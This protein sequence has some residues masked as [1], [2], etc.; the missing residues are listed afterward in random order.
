MMGDGAAGFS[1]MDVDT[2]VRHNLPVVILVGNNGIWGLEKHPMQAL[3][4]YDVAGSPPKHE[5]RPTPGGAMSPPARSFE[6]PSEMDPP[7][8]A[9]AVP[10]QHRHFPCRYLPATVDSRLSGIPC[11]RIPDPPLR[12]CEAAFPL[13]GD[14]AWV[15]DAQT[16]ELLYLRILCRFRTR[17]SRILI[18]SR[19]WP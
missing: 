6:S 14:A 10:H 18:T 15:I 2:L 8:T 11:T 1:L 4:G 17:L 7:S 13:P 12:D 19:L 5:V 16:P 3:Y 9:S